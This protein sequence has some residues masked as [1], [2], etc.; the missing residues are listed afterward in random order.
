MAIALATRQSSHHSVP[1]GALA[2]RADAHRPGYLRTIPSNAAPDPVDTELRRIGTSISCPRG[3]MLIGEGDVAEH[4]FKVESGALR[5]VR[6]LPDGR[7]YIINFLMPGDYFGLADA[8]HYSNSVEA[9]SDARVIR[10]SRRSFEAMVESDARVGQRFF[11]VMSKELSAAQNR[12]VL[13]GRKT[14]LER[15]AAFLLVMANAQPG[16]R[17]PGAREIDLPMSR[18]D[19]ADYLGLRIETISRILT[20]LRKQGVIALPDSHSFIL[21][22]RDAL[23]DLSEGEA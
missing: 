2:L 10:Y 9:V 5:V 13:L 3:K 8:K 22:D 12:L 15:L 14:A 19:V 23:N 7:R 11:F 4:L 16:D 18:S 17:R 20:A 21:L 1:A 6:L